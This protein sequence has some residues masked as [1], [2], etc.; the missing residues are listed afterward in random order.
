M[1]GVRVA[2]WILVSV[3]AGVSWACSAGRCGPGAPPDRDAGGAGWVVA[4][5]EDFESGAGLAHQ[6]AW[7]P[8]DH[9]DGDPFSDGGAYFRARGITPPPGFRLS[10]PLGKDGWLRVESYTRSEA[11]AFRDLLAVVPDPGGASNRVLRL[12]SPAHTDATVL[13]SSQPLPQRYRVSLS[14]GFADF[15]DGLPGSSNGYDGGE[16][17]EPWRDTSATDQNGFYWLAILDTAPL[18]RNNIWIHHHR[19]VVIDSDNHY[20]PWMEIWDGEEFIRSGERPIMMLGVDG[21]GAV[22]R[23]ENGKPFLSWSA[24]RVQPSGAI[25]AVDSY[26]PGTWYRAS[27]ERTEH[28]YVLEVSGVFRYGG[29]RTYRAVFDL[30]EHCIWHYN[31]PGEVARPE[32]IDETPLEGSHSPAP[33]WPAGLAWPDYFMFGDPHINY[34]EG[35]VYYDDIRLEVWREE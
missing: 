35:Q 34:Y 24:G 23:V 25:R 17:A 19:K 8:D 11:T 5:H 2:W 30:R 21:Q 26:L 1:T 16:R 12:R 3:L 6:P 22:A 32:C 27:I 14:V 18:P 9:P 31:R 28:A 13:R 4:Y 15:G 20:P 10:A 29:E 7:R 33:Q